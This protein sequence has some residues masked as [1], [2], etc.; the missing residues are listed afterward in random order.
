MSETHNSKCWYSYRYYSFQSVCVCFKPKHLVNKPQF[1]T[2]AE[3]CKPQWTSISSNS[4]DFKDLFDSIVCKKPAA[5]YHPHPHPDRL[6]GPVL[7]AFI[8]SP[9]DWA[10][11]T[12]SLEWKKQK[13]N[14]Y[15]LSFTKAW[16]TV[17]DSLKR[18]G[19]KNCICFLNSSF[20][21]VCP[22]QDWWFCTLFQC[23]CPSLTASH[24]LPGYP[25]C[26]ECEELRKGERQKGREREGGGWWW[27]KAAPRFIDMQI[28]QGAS[29]NPWEEKD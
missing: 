9:G 16:L 1:I 14:S 18:L 8:V 15:L 11:P 23:L 7:S 28:A 3:S 5:A 22:L 17:T 25:W 29:T 21:K 20:C 6:S 12:D 10:Y 26:Q 27:L 4:T 13:R 24:P 2:L 19:W